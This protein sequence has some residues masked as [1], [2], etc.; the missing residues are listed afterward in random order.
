MPCFVYVFIMYA[1]C[2]H[3]LLVLLGVY[4]GIEL[5][6]HMVIIYITFCLFLLDRIL[7]GSIGELLVLLWL[8]IWAS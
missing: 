5:L 1:L 7:L 8:G 4:L 2:G 6:S 3:L